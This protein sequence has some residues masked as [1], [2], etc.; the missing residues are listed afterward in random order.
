M[1]SQKLYLSAI[2]YYKHIVNMTFNSVH[3]IE[4]LQNSNLNVQELNMN[5]KVINYRKTINNKNTPIIINYIVNNARTYVQR[6]NYGKV[7]E[8]Q[9]TL[10]NDENSYFNVPL[11]LSGL[12]IKYKIGGQIR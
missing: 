3:N 10:S 8:F 6:L 12:T 5:L 2:N 7:N 1:T 4:E 9:Y 11:S